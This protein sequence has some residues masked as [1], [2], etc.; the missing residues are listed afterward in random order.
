[1]NP[2]RK[3]NTGLT[4]ALVLKVKHGHVKPE[5]LKPNSRE[6]AM[7]LV[8]ARIMEIDR[9]GFLRLIDEDGAMAA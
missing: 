9:R 4:P 8:K 2:K 6:I 7:R 3:S 5:E 1:M